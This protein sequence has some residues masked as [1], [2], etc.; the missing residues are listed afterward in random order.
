[1]TRADLSPR[2]GN[3]ASMGFPGTRTPPMRLFPFERV[4]EAADSVLNLSC[5]LVGLAVGLQLGIAKHLPATS[6]IL[7]MIPFSDPS[8]RSLSTICSSKK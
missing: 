8:I 3:N 6:L 4:L 7:P 2:A 5:R 1:M